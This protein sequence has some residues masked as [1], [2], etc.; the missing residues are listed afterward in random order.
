MMADSQSLLLKLEKGLLH[1]EWVQLYLSTE[2]E[3]QRSDEGGRKS[4]VSGWQNLKLSQLTG[5]VGAPTL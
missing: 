4:W 2:D 5:T 1:H 3:G